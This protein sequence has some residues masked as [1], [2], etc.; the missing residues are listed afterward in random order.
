MQYDCWELSAKDFQEARIET[1]T[2]TDQHKKFG[3][4][5]YKPYKLENK[6]QDLGVLVN[7]IGQK[8]FIPKD[9]LRIHELK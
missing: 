6:F 3:V 5:P 8:R 1:V 2:V 4:K 9:C 7:D